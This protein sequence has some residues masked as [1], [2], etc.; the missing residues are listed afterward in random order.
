MRV[1]WLTTAEHRNAVPDL[2]IV[3]KVPDLLYSIV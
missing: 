2:Y 1:F 3:P